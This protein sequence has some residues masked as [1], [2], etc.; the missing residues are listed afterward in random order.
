M[1]DPTP[2]IDLLN[3]DFSNIGRDQPDPFP[4]IVKPKPKTAGSIISEFVQNDSATDALAVAA[5]RGNKLANEGLGKD[6][7]TLNYGQLAA[8]YG[9]EIADQRHK[10]QPSLTDYA[11]KAVAGRNANEIIKDSVLGFG[12]G[13][14]NIVGGLTGLGLASADFVDRK[15]GEGDLGFDKAAEDLSKFTNEVTTNI[16]EYQSPELQGRR[17][18]QAIETQLDEADREAK[19]GPKEDLDFVTGLKR[20]GEEFLDAGDRILSD[21]AITGDIVAEALG[22]LLPSA[23]VVGAASKIVTGGASKITSNLGVQ[24]VAETLATAGAIGLSEASGTYQQT[25]SAIS[26]LSHEQLLETS[27][28]YKDL[29]ATGITPEQAKTDLAV[30]TS[31]EAFKKQLPMAA[32]LGLIVGRFERAPIASFK[33]QSL[34]QNLR[35]IGAQTFEEAGQGATGRLNQNIAL[36]ENV[37]PKTYL[38]EGIGEET[39]AGA[40]G[41]TGISTV[42]ATPSLAQSTGIEA[43]KQLK[44][45][46]AKDILNQ[47]VKS[48]ADAIDLGSTLATKAREVTKPLEKRLE[49]VVGPVIKKGTK[50]ASK[51]IKPITDRIEELADSTSNKDYKDTILAAKVIKIHAED[52]GLTQGVLEVSNEQVPSVFKQAVPE[53]PTIIESVAGTLATLAKPETKI[54]K[55]DNNAILY[56]NDKIVKLQNEFDNSPPSIKREIS[57]IISSPQI[58]RIQKKA[59]SIDLNQSQTTQTPVNLDTVNETINVAKANPTNVNPNFVTKILNHEDR[60]DLSDEDIRLLESAAK[61]ARSVNDYVESQVEI[62][63]ETNVAL[64]KKPAYKGKE[65]KLPEVLTAD[66]VSR[67]ITVSGFTDSRG[68][69]LRSVNDYAADIFTGAQ[70]KDKKFFNEKGISTPVETIAKQFELFVTH[71]SNK[72]NALNTSFDQNDNRGKGKPVLFESLVGGRKLVVA[73]SP[74]S[75]KPVTYHRSSPKS[76]EFAQKVHADAV[77]AAEVYNTLV[78]TF[79]DIVTG[80]KIQINDLK[81]VKDTAPVSE[82]VQETSTEE[83]TQPDLTFDEAFN[84]QEKANQTAQEKIFNDA[85]T[86]ARNKQIRNP[87]NDFEGKNEDFLDNLG[88][89]YLAVKHELNDIYP[90]RSEQE[91]YAELYRD[92][93]NDKNSFEGVIYD[94]VTEIINQTGNIKLSQIQK[95]FDIAQGKIPIPIPEVSGVETITEPVQETVTEEQTTATETPLSF[96][97]QVVEDFGYFDQAEF[98]TALQEDLSDIESLFK[99]AKEDDNS[100]DEDKLFDGRSDNEILAALTNDN[101]L[102]ILDGGIALSHALLTIKKRQGT[103]TTKQVEFLINRYGPS[104]EAVTEEVTETEEATFE[105]V[106]EEVIESDRPYNN[107]PQTFHDSFILNDEPAEYKN[108]DDLIQILSEQEGI[109]DKYIKFAKKILQPLIKVTANRLKTVK[110][111]KKDPRTVAE[112]MAAGEDLSKFRDYKNLFFIDR[113]TQTYDPDLLSLAALSVIDWLTTARPIESNLIESLKALNITLNDLDKIDPQNREE[114]LDNIVNGI[115]MKQITNEVSKIVRKAWNL[116]ANKDAPMVNGRGAIEGMLKEVITALDNNGKGKLISIKKIPIIIN[117]KPRE[118]DTIVVKPML[119]IQKSLGINGQG[120][121]QKYLT[122]EEVTLPSIGKKITNVDDRQS[123]GDVPLTKVERTALKNIQDT[124]HILAEGISNFVETLGFQSLAQLLGYRNLGGFNGNDILRV[125]VEGKNRSIEQDFD[126]AFRVVEGIREVSDDNP[127]SVPVHYPVGITKVGRHQMR[128]IN[129][130][131]NKILRALVTPTH[132]VLDMTTQEHQDA[133]WLTVAQASEIYKVENVNHETVLSDIQEKFE[134]EFAPAVEAVVSWLE[135]GSLN[136]NDFMAG[137]LGRHKKKGIRETVEMAQINAVMAVAELQFAKKNG[138]ENNFKTTLSFELDGKTDGAANMMA[139]FGQ[140]LLTRSDLSNFNRVGYFLGRTDGTLN[141]YFSAGNIDLYDI[142][143]R[144]AEELLNEEIRNAAPEQKEYLIALKNFAARFGDFRLD[145]DGTIHMTRATSKNPVTKT[146]YGS[147][148][149]SVGLEI[150]EDMIVNFYSK[151]IEVLDGQDLE[152]YFG[153][154]DMAKDIKIL[155]NTDL[156]KGIDVTTFKFNQENSADFVDSVTEILGKLISDTTKKTIGDPITKVNRLLVTISNLQADVIGKI[157]DRKLKELIEKQKAEGKIKSAIELSQRDYDNLVEELSTYAPMY[158]NGLQ[159][160]GLSTFAPLSSDMELSSNMDGKLKEKSVLKRPD[161]VSVRVIPYITQGRGDASMINRIYSANNAPTNTLPVFDGI[162]M[163]I[164]KV[165][166]YAPRINEAVLGNWDADVLTDVVAD[167]E[168]FLRHVGLDNAEMK[169]IIAKQQAVAAARG[170]FAPNPRQLLAQLIKYQKENLARKKAFKRIPV[171]VDHMGGSSTNYS[172]GE[173]TKTPMTHTEINEV[174]QEELNNLKQVEK[175]PAAE[176]YRELTVY[177]ARG[178]IRGLLRTIKDTPL[179]QTIRAISNKLPANLTVVTGSIDQLNAYRKANYTND[180]QILSNAGGYDTDNNV[181]FLSKNSNETLVH[182]LVHAATMQQVL[183]HYEG[184]NTN[185]AVTR[186]EALMQEFMSL[187][188][189]LS[190]SNVRTTVN[191][192]KAAIANHQTNTDNFSRAAALNEFMAWTLSNEQLAETL[193]RTRTKQANT[194]TKKVLALIRRLMG[195]VPSDIFSHIV[196]NTKLLDRTQTDFSPVISGDGGNNNGNGNNNNNDGEDNLTPSARNYTNFWINEVRKIL[197]SARNSDTPLSDLKRLKKYTD[198][199]ERVL[200]TLK[201]GGF[202]FDEEQSQTFKAIHVVLATEMKLDSAS[203]LAMGK[204]FDYINDNL[205]PEMFSSANRDQLYSAAINAFG[206]TQNEQGVSDAIAVMLALSQTSRAFREALDNMPEPESQRI[207]SGTLNEFLSTSTG[208]LMRKIVGSI[209][210]SQNNV[211]DTLDNLSESLIRQDSEKEYSILRKLMSNLDA[212]DRYTSGAVNELAERT[213]TL[214]QKVQASNRTRATKFVANNVALASSFLSERRTTIASEGIKRVT[215]MGQLLDNLVPVR[216]FVSEIIGTDKTNAE[217]VA[218]LDR[219]NYSVS[220]V[221]QAYREEVPVILQDLFENVPNKEQWKVLHNVLGRGD[222]S[223][224]FN[225]N[226]AD[227][228]MKLFNDDSLV[229]KKITEKTNAIKNN[230]ST[231]I[232]D[233][234]IEKVIQLAN[235][236]NGHGAGHL[237]LKNA[238]AINKLNGEYKSNMTKDIDELISLYVIQGT[239]QDYKDQITEIYQNDPEAIK[240]IMTYMQALNIEE[241]LKQV[242]EAARLN[243]YKGYIP[244][245][246]TQGNTLVIEED[247]RQ[248]DLEKMGFIRIADYPAEDAWSTISKGYYFTTV[249]QGG[250]YTQ[251]VIQTIQSTYRGVNAVTGLT[252]SGSTSGVIDG[253]SVNRINREMNRINSVPDDKETVTP[254]FDDD[255]N[256]AYYERAINPDILE[257]RLV[258]RSNLALMLGSWAGR[259]VEEKFAQQYNYELVDRLKGIYDSRGATD[260]G[261]FIDISNSKLTDPIYKDSWQVIPP[262]TKTYIREVFGEQFYVRKDMINL[263][264]GYREPSI[265]DIWTGKTRLPEAVQTSVKAM[266]NGLLGAAGLNAVTILSRTEEGLQNLISNA[267]DLIVVRSL[268]VP[269]MNIQAN[270]FQLFTKGVP[271]KQIVRGTKQKLAEIETFNDNTQKLIELEIRRNLA[272]ND[273]NQLRIVDNEIQIINDENRRL[274]IHPV[275]EAGAYKNISE[276]ITDL[277]IE[278]TSGRIS[279]WIEKQ[280]NKLPNNAQTIAKY[281]LLSKDTALYKGANKAVQYGDFI[282]KSVLYDFYTEQKNMD[283][284]QA[285]KRINE[286]FVN[287]SVPPGRTRSFFEINGGTWFF[288]FK[289][290]IMKIAM[291]NLRENPVRAMIVANTVGD[292]GSPVADNLVSVTAQDRLDY[293]LGWDMLFGAPNLNPWINMTQWAGE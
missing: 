59:K 281:G 95:L 147:S 73:G 262:Q 274:S 104:T 107:L 124:P 234:I 277:D 40:I 216:E 185:E 284:V 10:I 25:L 141:Q 221:R 154:P 264:L 225:L 176:E 144:T 51:A 131:N 146:V 252:V 24:K 164:S 8:K 123:R 76:A 103:V 260:D 49:P 21:T 217:V 126:N 196:F 242:S 240:S 192:V 280:I 215:H 37:D 27:Q 129:P 89:D 128:G 75:A 106:S 61:I 250:T 137:M 52:T 4:A 180:G 71:L 228:S 202:N 177:E 162:D 50:I 197:A 38:G 168:S 69:S 145:D 88:E 93:I 102:D 254:V 47:A 125:S 149:G 48:G 111:S 159:T 92:A 287:F 11:S 205:S 191:A 219:T 278:I 293:S 209:N 187:D 270:M 184:V 235:Y 39:A 3:E 195:N 18:L 271:T 63:K 226:R 55:L 275:I 80:P 91:N 248:A 105:R 212:A 208:F 276:G 246:P 120:I 45:I 23:K 231:N 42:L 273:P 230:F 236:M 188:F 201:F 150:A 172:R 239:N 249:K 161:G 114:I 272:Q 29:L 198:V 166:E 253:P 113:T 65:D 251:G 74:G 243:G 34:V 247:T 138:T 237:L 72:V 67:S 115:P 109:S 245:H 26:S 33:G 66:K 292:L 218:L 136:E 194:L 286:E 5:N 220:S 70:N 200:N 6:L 77:V 139:N 110:R 206:T 266:A 22:S 175:L 269:Y 227:Q 167:F 2:T 233:D 90:E 57:K 268:I 211:R 46:P 261:L 263:S 96:L 62:S 19:Y 257:Q 160:L 259:Q 112:I 153:Y 165:K 134:T 170:G 32:A 148:Y 30:S 157:F 291:Q 43:A 210:V 44:K 87:D 97:D 283:S 183:D 36:Q 83:L 35:S 130:Q 117:G 190:D 108:A 15:L 31:L 84:E 223:A 135:T 155:F 140:G 282:A 189:T 244:D 214:N 85:L 64:S 179:R 238:Y 81:K 41:G 133:F 121:L 152:I 28:V 151:I 256:I 16:R 53:N 20:T 178:L 265:L 290:R 14:A 78:D 224:L 213:D 255:G 132:D 9:K 1:A 56:A 258:P 127:T 13:T 222:F 119:E 203:M 54:S 17:E 98:I 12:S 7:L 101:N 285:L 158:S 288:A 241:D 99:T 79:P 169:E 68:E 118:I 181:I 232:A 58:A 116:K 122:P 94:T 156:S 182:E 60:K 86:K 143:S 163:P 229:S 289:I 279:Q 193:K 204:V 171:S 199:S 207:N 142:N 267:K 100:Q 173:I 186:L 82:S 174:I